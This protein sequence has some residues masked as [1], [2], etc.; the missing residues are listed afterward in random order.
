M[1]SFGVCIQTWITV[2]PWMKPCFIWEVNKLTF[3]M[4]HKSLVCGLVVTFCPQLNEM[5]MDANK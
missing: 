1:P 5:K 2:V 3:R 4:G